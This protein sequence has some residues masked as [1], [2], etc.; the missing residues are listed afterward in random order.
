[1]HKNIL[2]VVFSR[3][4]DGTAAAIVLPGF[5][6]FGNALSIKKKLKEKKQNNC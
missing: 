5:I 4:D 6:V 1:M 3:Y 2:V